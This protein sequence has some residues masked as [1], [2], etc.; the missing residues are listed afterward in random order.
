M[1]R[2]LLLLVLVGCGEMPE[3]QGRPDPFHIGADWLDARDTVW[4]FYGETDRVPSLVPVRADQL[5]C[6]LDMNGQ[7]VDSL[8]GD[9]R[10]WWVEGGE[11]GEAAWRECIV[12][13]Y[14]RGLNM[15]SI[16]VY[17]G[18]LLGGTLPHELW[19]AHLARWGLPDVGHTDPGFQQGGAVEQ[20]T[21]LLQH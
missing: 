19:H 21:A 14:I 16:A 12:G 13:H 2:A 5:D 11:A 4:A 9:G 18:A 8:G 20:A 3:P 6:D 10:G 7:P 1:K 15:I 17:E